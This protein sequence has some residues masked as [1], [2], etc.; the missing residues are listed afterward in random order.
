M[1]KIS[2]SCFRSAVYMLPNNVSGIVGVG[3]R[4]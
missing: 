2:V 4:R 1:L 3:L